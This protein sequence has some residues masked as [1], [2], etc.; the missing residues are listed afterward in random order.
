MYNL[1]GDYM[2][3]YEE[4]EIEFKS[5]LSKE[6]FDTLIEK[7]SLQDKFFK[8]YNYYFDTDDE[9][10][11]KNDS[12]FR[13]RLKNGNYKL[14]YKSKKTKNSVIEKSIDLDFDRAMFY[15]ENGYSDELIDADLP[16][17]FH[18]NTLMT[19]RVSFMIDGGEIFI[20]KNFYSNIVDY[21][22][23]FECNDE[24]KGIVIFEKFLKDNSITFRESAPKMVRAF[25]A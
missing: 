11:L 16:E 15:L 25:R 20:D 12:A 2:S 5:L 13:I 4:L 23:E 18:C 22:V 6:E 21:E 19:E 3:M 14:T 1:N 24:K 10:I 8:Q 7:F 9:Y 17:L